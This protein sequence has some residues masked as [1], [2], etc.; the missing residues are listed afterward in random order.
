MDDR[1]EDISQSTLFKKLCEDLPNLTEDLNA[2]NDRYRQFVERDDA[3]VGV[4]LK[5]HLIV[6]HFLDCYLAAA[7]PA[8]QEWHE[9]RL[10]FAQKLALADNPRSA[11]RVLMPGLRCLNALRN[12]LAHQLDAKF[13][14]SAVGPIQEFMTMWN[15]AAG[16][17]IPE[18]IGLLEEFALLAS[19]W[20]HGD[21]RMIKRHVPD[22]G[23]LGL[24]EW[25]Q[26]EGS[27]SPEAINV[28]DPSTT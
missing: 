20:L 5:C 25:Y 23:L 26:A 12:R 24:L 14:E 27:G 10:T 7:N 22:R 28:P 8:I 15:T 4:I 1:L 21:S 6:E 19:A 17:H 11:I 9:A 18:G 2:F 3:A 13:E 16:K